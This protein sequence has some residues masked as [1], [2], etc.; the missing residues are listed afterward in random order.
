MREPT[1]PDE[2][3]S[4]YL[5]GCIKALATVIATAV[6]TLPAD[7]QESI[8]NDV[9][10]IHIAF[11]ARWENADLDEKG[12][13]VQEIGTSDTYGLFLAKVLE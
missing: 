6:K 1:T 2:I 4:D 7:Q 12:A 5:M 8:V 10:K 11:E 13:R 9:A 3:T